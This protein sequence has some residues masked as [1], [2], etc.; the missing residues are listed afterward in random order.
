MPGVDR[1]GSADKPSAWADALERGADGIQ[2]DRPA[3][4]VSFLQSSKHR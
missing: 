4:L 1:L 2:T 3:E